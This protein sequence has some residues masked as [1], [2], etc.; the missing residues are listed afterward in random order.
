MGCPRNAVMPR[1]CGQNKQEDA[2]RRLFDERDDRTR[3]LIG[4]L[5]CEVLNDRQLGWAWVPAATLLCAAR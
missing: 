1:G 4:P 5:N 3:D 2:V